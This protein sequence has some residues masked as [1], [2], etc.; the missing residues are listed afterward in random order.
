MTQP[1]IRESIVLGAATL[2]LAL[3]LA[4]T[5]RQAQLVEV[6]S[7]PAVTQTGEGL[8]GTRITLTSYPPTTSGW[9]RTR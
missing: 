7:A 1:R 2:W 6:L 9:R 8:G 5:A 3:A 4:E